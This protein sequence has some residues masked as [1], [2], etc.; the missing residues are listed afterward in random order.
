MTEIARK[1]E[2]RCPDCGADT[3]AGCVMEVRNYFEGAAEPSFADESMR[4]HSYV[5]LGHER[6][7]WLVET[8][9][10]TP[11][12]VSLGRMGT[13]PLKWAEEFATIIQ[14]KLGWQISTDYGEDQHGFV[15]TREVVELMVGW[16]AN[17]IQA[18]R[19][20]EHGRIVDWTE[21][22]PVNGVW[23]CGHCG[24][25]LM[26]KDDLSCGHSGVEPEAV[27]SVDLVRRLHAREPS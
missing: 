24:T 4:I 11:D 12:G 26:G 5:C 25:V 2:L 22:F 6:P 20:Q 1:T 13:D 3:T 10:N 7:Y 21:H 15:A 9:I 19:G 18:G 27:H 17:A 16:F 8:E 23:V 14:T